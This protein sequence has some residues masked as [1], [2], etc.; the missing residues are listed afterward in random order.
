[1][2]A[3]SIRLDGLCLGPGLVSTAYATRQNIRDTISLIMKASKLDQVFNDTNQDNLPQNVTYRWFLYVS[4]R[5]FR[6]QKQLEIVINGGVW[7]QTTSLVVAA[8]LVVTSTGSHQ[9]RKDKCSAASTHAFISIRSRSGGLLS[10][11]ILYNL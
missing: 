1:M 2:A 11:R 6:A 3:Q 5:S 7:W 8:A 4:S 9:G 10:R